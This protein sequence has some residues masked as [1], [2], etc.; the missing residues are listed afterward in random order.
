M[1][2][3]VSFLLT[4]LLLAALC[5]ASALAEEPTA[6]PEQAK[7]V[8]FDNMTFWV[9]GQPFTLGV[10]TLQD[11][12]DAGVAFHEVD[13]EDAN[14]NLRKNLQSE[15]F[16]FDIGANSYATV[17]VL[18]DTDKGKRLADCVLSRIL[19]SFSDHPEEMADSILT[20]AFPYD[21]TKEQLMENAGDPDDISH[22]DGSRYASDTIEYKRGGQRYFGY[23]RFTF[24][25]H[26]EVLDYFYIEYLP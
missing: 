19:V 4:A 6:A 24:V 13:L 12:I 9:N 21:M 3:F 8:D 25:F 23:N 7:Y 5:P 17:K 18:N 11:M 15:G 1:K 10:S 22:Y 14:N 20:F 16:T 26:D 2:R